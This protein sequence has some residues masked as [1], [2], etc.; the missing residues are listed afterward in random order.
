MLFVVL[1]LRLKLTDPNAA[2][3]P[4]RPSKSGTLTECEFLSS[5]SGHED[6]NG[7]CRSDRAHGQDG[8]TIRQTAPCAE[9]SS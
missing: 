1:L 6:R 5:C 4:L 3:K 2:V 8:V 9:S 7:S